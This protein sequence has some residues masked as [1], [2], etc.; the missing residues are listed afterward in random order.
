MEDKL[1]HANDA[2]IRWLKDRTQDLDVVAHI[3]ELFKSSRDP[4][5]QGK[6]GLVSVWLRSLEMFCR[7]EA[8]FET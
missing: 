4:V 3:K 8:V 5:G 1:E 2:L 7:L 6:V